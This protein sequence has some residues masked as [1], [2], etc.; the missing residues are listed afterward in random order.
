MINMQLFVK[1]FKVYHKGGHLVLSVLKFRNSGVSPKGDSST[2]KRYEE[3]GSVSDRSRFGRPRK[4]T[5]RNENYIFREI[6]KNPSSSY[7]KRALGYAIILT[8]INNSFIHGPLPSPL[9]TYN[10]LMRYLQKKVSESHNQRIYKKD[11]SDVN[12]DL[13]GQLIIG[14]VRVIFSDES[15]FEVFNRKSNVIFH[16]K[17][18]IPRLQ[19]GGGSAGIWGCISFKGTSKCNINTGR[20]NQFV[21]INT[22]EKH[23]FTIC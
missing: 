22:F 14:T 21:Y 11:K 16:P 23:S 19:N 12:R 10:T 18:C 7:Q 17:F 8:Q 2:K 20:I 9:E 3:T 4:L 1:I 15:N 5:F 13:I 6:R